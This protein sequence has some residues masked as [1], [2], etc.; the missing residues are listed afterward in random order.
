MVLCDQVSVDFTTKDLLWSAALQVDHAYDLLK[1]ISAY[2]ADTQTA[3]SNNF[4]NS[5]FAKRGASGTP[6]KTT[7]TPNNP[8]FANNPR[9][10]S[11]LTKNNYNHSSNNYTNNKKSNSGP[12]QRTGN[13]SSYNKDDKGKDSKQFGSSSKLTSYPS[14]P[15]TDKAGNPICY[16]CGKIGLARDCPRHPYKPRVFTLGVNDELIEAKPGPQELD[17]EEELEVVPQDNNH[18]QEDL[19]PGRD[20]DRYV[21]DPYDPS[22]FEILDEYDDTQDAQGEPLGFNMLSVIDIDDESYDLKL[23][24]AKQLERLLTEEE[25]LASLIDGYASSSKSDDVSKPRKAD[26]FTQGTIGPT[27]PNKVLKRSPPI[28][29][30]KLRLSQEAGKYPNNTNADLRATLT[31]EKEI[32]VAKAFS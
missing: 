2:K 5:N 19:E 20:E 22:H 8:R 10:N 16:K 29:D 13:Y 32:G 6:T 7:T 28:L 3:T 30:T 18:A 31:R 14:R 15:S 27:V 4:N 1:A 17:Q 11:T 26:S 12:N 21:D 9:L 24:S 25:K 23:A